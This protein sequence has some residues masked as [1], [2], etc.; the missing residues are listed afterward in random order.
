MGFRPDPTT[1]KLNFAGT[2]LDGLEVIMRSVS[3]K[4]FNEMLRLGVAGADTEKVVKANERVIEMFTRALVEWNLETQA[5]DAVPAT[6]DG[7]LAQESRLVTRMIGAW[8]MA[9]V[10]V[11]DP[12]PAA[13]GSGAT[14]PEASLDLASAS[15]SLSNSRKRS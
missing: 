10:T 14:T 3:V 1:Y 6:K 11:P 2:D 5:G 15:R 4:E 9:L 7:V 13:S 12:L 8:Q